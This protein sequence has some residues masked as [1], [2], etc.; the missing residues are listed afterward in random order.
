MEIDQIYPLTNSETNSSYKDTNS[1]SNHSPIYQNT[2]ESVSVSGRIPEI[3]PIYSNTNGERF[4]QPHPHAMS[5]GETLAHHLRHS[6]GRA[7]TNTQGKYNMVRQRWRI[8]VCVLN[9]LK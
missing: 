9:I 7:N 6:L 2:S 4:K 1:N 3:T 8:F 5:Y